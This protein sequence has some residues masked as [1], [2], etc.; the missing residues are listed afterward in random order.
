MTSVVGSS[1]GLAQHH[2]ANLEQLGQ[3]RILVTSLARMTEREKKIGRS[4]LPANQEASRQIEERQEGRAC[5][6]VAVAMLALALA[7]LE[8]RRRHKNLCTAELF[9]NPFFC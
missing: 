2:G 4:F 6:P 9:F 1:H 7:A 3:V 8:M 5:M